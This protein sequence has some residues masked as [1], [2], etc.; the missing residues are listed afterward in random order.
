MLIFKLPKYLDLIIILKICINYNVLR[1]LTGHPK[2]KYNSFTINHN[3]NL[4]EL[5]ESGTIISSIKCYWVNDS[6]NEEW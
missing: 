5:K 3:I 6:L 2:Y 4:F 1:I